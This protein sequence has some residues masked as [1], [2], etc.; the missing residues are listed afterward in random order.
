MRRDEDRTLGKPTDEVKHI[1]ETVNEQ[2]EKQES[3]ITEGYLSDSFK[4][5]VTNSFK[6]R[7]VRIW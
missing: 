4:E 6:S 1:K 3:C 7:T 2:K 5:S